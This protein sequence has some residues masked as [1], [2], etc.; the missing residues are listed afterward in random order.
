[1]YIEGRSKEERGKERGHEREGR[2]STV[3]GSP[4]PGG[5]AG[6]RIYVAG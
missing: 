1:M 6:R 3:D 5:A 2:K 4:S